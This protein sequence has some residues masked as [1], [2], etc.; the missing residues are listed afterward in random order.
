MNNNFKITVKEIAREDVG[1]IYLVQ[2]RGQW[3]AC[4][5]G[6]ESKCIS[7][8]H[9]DEVNYFAIISIEISKG[10]NGLFRFIVTFNH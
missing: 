7:Y 3:P 9:E 10:T 6:K 8:R 1:W 2:D 5:H 4:R